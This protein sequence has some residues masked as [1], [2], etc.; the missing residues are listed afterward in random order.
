MKPNG[1]VSA[2]ILHL[3]HSVALRPETNRPRKTLAFSAKPD[4]SSY[5]HDERIPIYG[6]YP[7]L[8]AQPSGQRSPRMHL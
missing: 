6:L 3:Q 4:V 5:Q 7:L 2:F 8:L 1:F